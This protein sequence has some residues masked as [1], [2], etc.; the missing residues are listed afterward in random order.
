MLLASKDE[1]MERSVYF[2]SW[3]V[4]DELLRVANRKAEVDDHALLG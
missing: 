2:R 1:A 3:H 4:F